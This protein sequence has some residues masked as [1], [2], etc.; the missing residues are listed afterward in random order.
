[1]GSIFVCTVDD[2]GKRYDR[3][4]YLFFYDDKTKCFEYVFVL[5]SSS[6]ATQAR[7]SDN[8]KILT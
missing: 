3:N 7:K 8:E 6:V 2:F 5:F 4:N 1:M